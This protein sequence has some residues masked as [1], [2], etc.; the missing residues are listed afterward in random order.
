MITFDIIKRQKDYLAIEK[1]YDLYHIEIEGVNI[2]QFYRTELWNE[3]WVQKGSETKGDSTRDK[4]GEI[5]IGKYEEIKIFLKKAGY[6]F[7][8]NNRKKIHPADVLFLTFG[9][10]FLKNGVYIDKYTGEL[11][12]CFRDNFVIIE[13]NRNFLLP[14]IPTQSQKEYYLEPLGFMTLIKSRIEIAFKKSEYKNVL[15]NVEKFFYKPLSEIERTF[16]YQIDLTSFYKDMAM[17]ILKLKRFKKSYR[18]LL[19]KVSPKVI[20]E[21]IPNSRHTMIIN[22]IAKEMKIPTIDLQHAFPIHNL[23]WNYADECGEIRQFPDYEFGYSDYFNHFMHLPISPENI[24]TVGLPYLERSLLTYPKSK[25]D[26]RV[27]ILFISQTPIAKQL[28]KLAIDIREQL[29][30]DRYR[31]I[32]KLH[33]AEASVWKDNLPWLYGR[34]DIDVIDDATYE[35]YRCFAVSDIQIGVN[36][37]AIFEGM[38]YELDTYIYKTIYW[39]VMSDAIDLGYATLITDCNDFIDKLRNRAN[40]KRQS[41][42]FFWKGNAID[43]M[44]HEIELISGVKGNIEKRNGIK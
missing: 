42:E 19:K 2:W 39:E 8:H 15:K 38:A 20:L 23:I 12:T 44:L 24:K 11:E 35:T 37:T 26:N 21:T 36:S 17:Q 9:R 25:A 3:I 40:V 32:Y 34:D 31:I 33:P 5:N 29:D 7:T 28:S 18:K 1:K 22:E 16:D 27:T 4:R 13:L 10:K 43:N 30:I 6:A 41:K 14:L